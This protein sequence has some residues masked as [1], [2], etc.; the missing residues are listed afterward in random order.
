MTGLN[1]GQVKFYISNKMADPN[2]KTEAIATQP[3]FIYQFL[4]TIKLST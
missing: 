3:Q 1:F 2:Y 4:E